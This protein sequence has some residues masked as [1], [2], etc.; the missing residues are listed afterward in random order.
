MHATATAMLQ[1]AILK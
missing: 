1:A